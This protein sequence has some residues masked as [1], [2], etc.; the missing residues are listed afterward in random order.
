MFFC[1]H[2][3]VD[4]G[5][6]FSSVYW[7]G[8]HMPYGWEWPAWVPVRTRGLLP[9]PSLSAPAFL[10][11]LHCVYQIKLKKAINESTVTRCRRQSFR[12]A[13]SSFVVLTKT[14]QFLA[15]SSNHF[16]GPKIQFY[17]R[18][19]AVFD[20]FWRVLWHKIVMCR[21]NA[22]STIKFKNKHT[23]THISLFLFV[24]VFQKQT[25][26]TLIRYNGWTENE[27]K[28]SGC[29][30][31]HHQSNQTC[32]SRTLEKMRKTSRDAMWHE[33]FR[34]YCN[35]WD[36]V[37]TLFISGL[38]NTCVMYV[39]ITSSPDIGLI[40]VFC[41]I[42]SLMSFFHSLHLVPQVKAWM[43]VDC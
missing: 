21:D 38:W 43:K 9:P 14:W 8:D 25:K 39:A 12:P 10:S 28:S 17:L 27:W 31:N 7:A 3:W 15:N 5:R 18:Q 40:L 2:E 35:F 29:Q 36:K 19:T 22:G 1:I 13:G 37:L 32:C 11:F 42:T 20:I 4:C 23:H 26:Q 24:F 41:H 30:M 33:A 34:P 6:R 16:V